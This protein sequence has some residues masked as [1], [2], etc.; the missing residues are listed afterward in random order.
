MDTL[1][2]YRYSLPAF[3]GGARGDSLRAWSVEVQNAEHIYGTGSEVVAQIESSQPL[4]LS[5]YIQSINMWES[6]VVVLLLLALYCY[7]LFRYSAIIKHCFRA[8]FSISDSLELFENQP[9]VVTTFF[10]FSRYFFSLSLAVAISVLCYDVRWE[11]MGFN[12]FYFILVLCVGLFIGSMFKIALRRLISIYDPS[13][14]RW[15]NLRRIVAYNKAM[16]SVVLTPVVIVFSS[17]LAFKDLLLWSIVALMGYHFIRIKL[18]FNVQ[19][20]SFMQ[21]MLYLC[22]VEIAPFVVLWGIVRHFIF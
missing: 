22:A 18:L 21:S 8:L 12:L 7:Q 4:A 9:L 3:G 2:Q 19:G 17:S 15:G 14:Y 11:D 10:R 13:P 16:G 6:S 20:F 5:D 1:T